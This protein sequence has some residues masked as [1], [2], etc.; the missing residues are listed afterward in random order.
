MLGRLD[1]AGTAL[2]PV[3]TLDSWHTQVGA[4][5]PNVVKIDV[6]GAEVAVIA[7]MAEILRSAR[8]TLIVELHGATNN[9][10]VADAL[11]AHG[12]QH[13]PIDAPGTTRTVP[14]GAHILATPH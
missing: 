13:S 7:G 1:D 14:F 4:P 11:E 8:P 5:A 10:A 9:D 12:Y 3:V 2:V 6:E